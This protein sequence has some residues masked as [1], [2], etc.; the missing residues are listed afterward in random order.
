[1]D[2]KFCFY[3]SCQFGG[4]A[5]VHTIMPTVPLYV[6]YIGCSERVVGFVIGIFTIT[7]MLFRPVAGMLL[8]KFGRKILLFSGIALAALICGSYVLANTLM[9]LLL[10]RF[11]HG[12]AFS[13]SHTAIGTTAVDVLPAK[14]LGQGLGYFAITSSI[15]MAVAPAVGLWMVEKSG[16]FPM[17]ILSTS[18]AVLAFIFS[19]IATYKIDVKS[20]KKQAPKSKGLTWSD[21]VEKKAVPASIIVGL[22]AML[23]GAV[24]SIL[25]LFAAQNGIANV[26]IFFTVN[27]LAMIVSRPFADGLCNKKGKHPVLLGGVAMLG[28]CILIIYLSTN[29]THIIMAGIFY[30]IGFGFCSP[31]LQTLAISDVLP[32]RRGTATGTFFPPLTWE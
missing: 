7:A 1:M 6:S 29:I 15:S 24:I 11:L 32:E 21:F 30:G 20:I 5:N 16:F 19:L 18:L 9:L 28:V 13:L 31:V 14:R 12:L 23:F 26:G 17:F 22:L 8:D 4:A 25:V 2:S 10:M 3:M 27:A